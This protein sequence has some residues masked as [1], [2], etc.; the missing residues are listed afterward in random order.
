MAPASQN[1]QADPLKTSFDITAKGVGKAEQFFK[2]WN[3]SRPCTITLKCTNGEEL[4]GTANEEEFE[5]KLKEFAQKLYSILDKIR[6]SSVK[7]QTFKFEPPGP[8]SDV[9]SEI[10]SEIYDSYGDDFD[11]RAIKM[12]KLAARATRT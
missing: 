8:K 4:E 10:V 2:S 12:K 5:K 9:T 1:N 3:S 7:I 11:T 6:D